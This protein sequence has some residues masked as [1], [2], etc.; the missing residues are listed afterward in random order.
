VSRNGKRSGGGR[1]ADSSS[2]CTVVHSANYHG[3]PTGR[4]RPRGKRTLRGAS[5]AERATERG[6]ACGEPRGDTGI[7][8]TVSRGLWHRS[9]TD[10]F[11]LVS[12]NRGQ[13]IEGRVEG[14]G[15][16]DCSVAG[17]WATWSGG[18][19]WAPQGD[20]LH[21]LGLP[22]AR[23]RAACGVPGRDEGLKVFVAVG[24]GFW[25]LVSLACTADCP[26][27]QRQHA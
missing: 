5:L 19:R 9:L 13:L 1:K 15:F 4:G 22:G 20:C 21:C 7:G 16:F 23:P 10:G 11:D 8:G 3:A 26:T 27:E 14:M 2:S 24:A 17:F 18:M 25:R 6:R 12:L